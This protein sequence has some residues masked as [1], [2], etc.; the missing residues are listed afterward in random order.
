LIYSSSRIGSK[1]PEE[2]FL[3]GLFSF[4][5]IFYGLIKV[6]RLPLDFED[7]FVVGKIGKLGLESILS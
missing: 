2:F 1:I 5:G 4:M 6:E 7:T 3:V